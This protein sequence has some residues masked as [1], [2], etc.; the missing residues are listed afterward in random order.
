MW[1]GWARGAAL[2]GAML[3]LG[4]GGAVSQDFGGD[5]DSADGALHL[6]QE[7][8]QLSGTYEQDNGRMTGT[9]KGDVATGFWGED[10]SAADCGSEKMGTRYWGNFVFTLS[11]DG[12]AFTGIW[13]YCDKT[14]STLWSAG[15]RRGGGDDTAGPVDGWTVPVGGGEVQIVDKWNTA[16]CDYTDH[17]TLDVDRPM[18]L[19]RIQLWID[20]NKVP[21]EGTLDYRVALDGRPIGG[22][23]LNRGDCDPYQ[24]N[25]CAADDAPNVKLVPGRYTIR[26]K[27]QALCQN[28]DSNGEGF[29]RA[30]DP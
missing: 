24:H 26:I 10:F 16:A 11:A 21:G 1:V 19:T 27:P 25:W 30:W 8:G 14:P 18:F 6:T 22:G 13:N 2:A 20:W 12:Q 29:I 17:A 28:A 9:V 3:M 15:T 7:S 23:V 5:W 4:V